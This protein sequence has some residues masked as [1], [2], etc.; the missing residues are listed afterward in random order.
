M[1]VE[2]QQDA[3]GPTGAAPQPYRITNTTSLD[4][5]GVS[6]RNIKPPLNGILG[7]GK[8]HGKGFCSLSASSSSTQGKW[9]ML[10]KL[11]QD[12]QQSRL[13]LWC[14]DTADNRDRQHLLSRPTN[15]QKAAKTNK[16]W[17]NMTDCGIIPS[18]QPSLSP[19]PS[20]WASP[21]LN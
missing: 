4:T 18:L 20:G 8:C 17:G 19:L 15:L 6:K 3:P 11:E 1:P 21:E 12:V 2:A 16:L 7:P 10:K 14:E 5:S 13:E 9:E